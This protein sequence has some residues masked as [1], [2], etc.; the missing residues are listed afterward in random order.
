MY[1]LKL[2]KTLTP[3]KWLSYAQDR[4][5]LMIANELNRL[6]NGIEAEQNAEQL[7]ECMERI[8]EL[9]DLTVTCSNERNFR[10]ELLRLRDV[11]AEIYL[12]GAEKSQDVIYNIYKV[13][14]LF[15]TN[16]SKLIL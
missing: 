10:R 9:W 4:Q 15:K 12:N 5:I 1:E 7:F 6:K 16:T 13:L 2:H 3:E 8:F 11:F 14:L